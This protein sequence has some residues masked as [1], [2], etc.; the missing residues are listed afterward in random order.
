MP[1]VRVAGANSPTPN[2]SGIGY[3]SGTIT[4]PRSGRWHMSIAAAMGDYDGV[5]LDRMDVLLR[6][7]DGQTKIARGVVNPYLSVGFSKDFILK[8]GDTVTAQV[9]HNSGTIKGLHS[10]PA[11][12]WW[13]FKYI[14]PA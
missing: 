3:S 5:N 12:Q 4:I 6:C 9:K 2:E 1:L 14:G 13:D 10:D 7:S 8:E 11:S